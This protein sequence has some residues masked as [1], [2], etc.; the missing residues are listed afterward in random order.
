M[1]T[2]VCSKCRIKKHLTEFPYRNKQKG[3]IHSYCLACGR[4]WVKTHYQSNVQYYVKKARERR[5]AVVDDLNE[6]VYNYLE[7]HPCIDCGE[8]DPVVLE[9]DHVRGKK[10]YEVST[11]HRRLVSWNTLLKEI[12]KCEV[13]CAN[14][15]R[16][17]TAKRRSY[18]RY[19]R[20][21]GPLAQ[22]G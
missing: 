10:L 7:N 16:R 8:S 11:L 12:A 17:T 15:H 22:F 6:K 4:I 19:V 13:R 3:T 1:E 21:Y 9:F 18:Y 2:R 14:C 20:R 5:K